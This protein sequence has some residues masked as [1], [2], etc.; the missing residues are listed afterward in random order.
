MVPQMM[1]KFVN[2]CICQSHMHPGKD[3]APTWC[4]R[5]N[6]MVVLALWGFRVVEVNCQE[7][8]VWSTTV[9]F[10]QHL[11][12]IEDTALHQR[13]FGKC[14]IVSHKELFISQQ[15]AKSVPKLLPNLVPDLA[16]V[17]NQA[18]H[19]RIDPL[20]KTPNKL[21]ICVPKISIRFAHRSQNVAA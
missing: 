21:L 9:F 12:S 14:R 7:I 18:K 2:L 1:R 15:V 19:Q 16:Q 20:G 11:R 6:N 5:G 13:N 8:Q 17:S 10:K 3:L 4:T